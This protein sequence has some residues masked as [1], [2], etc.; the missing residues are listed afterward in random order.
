MLL[1]CCEH[2]K[3]SE[4][5]GDTITTSVK[6]ESERQTL[7]VELPVQE[8]VTSDGTGIMQQCWGYVGRYWRIPEEL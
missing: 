4:Q 3:L 5:Y 6:A 8:S 2:S 1:S 7:E